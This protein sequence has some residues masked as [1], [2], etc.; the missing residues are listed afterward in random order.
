MV[1][2]KATIRSFRKVFHLFFQLVR[3]RITLVENNENISSNAKIVKVFKNYFDKIVVSLDINQNLE[4]VRESLIEDSVLT[5]TE[6]HSTYSAIKI[7]KSRINVINSNFFFD[8][9]DQDQVF[10][11]IKK[12]DGN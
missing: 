4:C 1:G 12:L 9:V 10:N 8:F 2:L 6:K 11:E 3:K 7:I 5:S